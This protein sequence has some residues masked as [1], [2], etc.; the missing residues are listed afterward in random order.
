MPR[1]T[2]KHLAHVQLLNDVAVR[3][4]IEVSFRSF[5]IHFVD[6][7]PIFGLYLSLLCLGNDTQSD[8]IDTESAYLTSPDASPQRSASRNAAQ[9]MQQP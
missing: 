8:G 4:E 1:L 6:F 9:R 3:T 5:R 2:I 7:G